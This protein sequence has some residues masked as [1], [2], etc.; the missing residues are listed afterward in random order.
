M[1]DNSNVGFIALAVVIV[2][3]LAIYL[4]IK[5]PALYK[6]FSTVVF[7]G[8][9]VGSAGLLHWISTQPH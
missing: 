5:F 3:F 7:F 1:L 6:A 9:I 4:N 8:L 2:V